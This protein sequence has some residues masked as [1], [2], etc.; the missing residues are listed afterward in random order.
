[1]TEA[2]WDRC[3][4]PAAMLAFL[5]QAG[6]ASDRKLRL[7]AC[8]CVRRVWPLLPQGVTHEAV[9][10]AEEFADG[11][12]TSRDL[13]RVRK[14]GRIPFLHPSNFVALSLAPLLLPDLSAQATSD[15]AEAITRF[16]GWE[17]RGGRPVEYVIHVEAVQAE[18]QAQATLLHDLFGNPFRRPGALAPSLLTPA[19]L[20]L[21]RSAYDERHLPE[22]TLDPRRLA[23]LADAL[24]AAG[25]T[26]AG[27]LGH[28]RSAGPH[29][30][31]C[32][33]LDT[34]LTKG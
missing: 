6:R 24:A 26:D 14:P 4:D 8:A 18:R 17:C 28:L 2:D 16:V 9:R 32:W 31:G 22:G 7:W 5:Q 12:A 3:T 29:V 34:V 21:A 15:M 20:A 13:G 11:R 33:A 10:L 30:R 23:A 1:M 19:I 27:L 25:C